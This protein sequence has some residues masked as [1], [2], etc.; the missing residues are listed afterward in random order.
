MTQPNQQ[1]QMNG[2]S[3]PSVINANPNSTPPS[4]PNTVII[5]KKQQ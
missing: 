1:G 3:T 5:Q 4:K 2:M